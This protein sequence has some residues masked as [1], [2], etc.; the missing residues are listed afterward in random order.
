[1][2]ISNCVVCSRK[3]SRSVKEKEARGLLSSIQL[4]ILLSRIALVGPLLF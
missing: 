2:A 4:K 1:M 3:R